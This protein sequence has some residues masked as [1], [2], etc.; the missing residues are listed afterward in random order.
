[1]GD[2][3]IAIAKDCRKTHNLETIKR[4]FVQ[5]EGLLGA[6]GIVLSEFYNFMETTLYEPYND[7]IA[8]THGDKTKNMDVTPCGCD[9]SAASHRL[10]LTMVDLL[11]SLKNNA[12]A[13]TEWKRKRGAGQSTHLQLGSPALVLAFLYKEPTLSL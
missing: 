13:Q 9:V 12:G 11:T 2:Q 5:L 7:S 1:M 4:K 3:V 10:N 6:H 8:V